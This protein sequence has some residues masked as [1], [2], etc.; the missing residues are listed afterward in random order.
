V[1]VPVGAI[2]Y[3]QGRCPVC[4][5]PRIVKTRSGFQGEAELAGLTLDR[6]GLPLYDIFT[7]RCTEEGRDDEVAYVMAGDAS[8]VLGR[9][10]EGA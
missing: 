8:E 5:S 6:L 4:E 10:V 9:N 7:A 3:Q 2:T 1:M